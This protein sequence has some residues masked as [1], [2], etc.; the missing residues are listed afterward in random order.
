[1]NEITF[2]KPLLKYKNPY[3]ELKYPNL[4]GMEVSLSLQKMLENM[5]QREHLNPKGME[6]AFPP[7]T[8]LETRFNEKDN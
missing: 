4:K 6:S 5:I 2:W 7:P 8:M 1:M 3:T